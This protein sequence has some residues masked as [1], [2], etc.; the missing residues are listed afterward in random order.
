MGDLISEVIKLAT[1]NSQT[2]KGG[3]VLTDLWGLSSRFLPERVFIN[4]AQRF[5]IINKRYRN[6][7]FLTKLNHSREE[8]AKY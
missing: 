2:S 8:T 3:M 6:I 5:V 1:P 7:P 4:L